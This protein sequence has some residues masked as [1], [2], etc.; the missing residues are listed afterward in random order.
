METKTIVTEPLL[1]LKGRSG[2]DEEAHNL[3]IMDRML[4]AAS[5]GQEYRAD[6]GNIGR[7]S[8][9]ESLT[10]VYK[11]DHGVAAVLRRAGYYD[12]PAQNNEWEDEPVLI[13]FELP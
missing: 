8:F 6:G 2:Y 12:S 9:E 1:V 3:P 5:I 10:V 4:R 11:D 13:W 7:D